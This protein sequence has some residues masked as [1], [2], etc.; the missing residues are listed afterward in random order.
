[1]L[2]G[3]MMKTEAVRLFDAKTRLSELVEHV[4]HDGEGFLITRRGKP[5]ARLVPVEQSSPVEDALSQLLAAR[6]AS[7][8]GSDS[9]RSL[10]DDGRRL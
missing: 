5:V 8:P 6:N 9:M 10:I 7:A 2:W 3:S 1:M 4:L